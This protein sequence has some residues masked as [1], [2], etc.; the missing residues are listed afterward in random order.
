M[1]YKCILGKCRSKPRL[2]SCS[3]SIYKCFSGG[4]G[5]TA[6]YAVVMA[7][8]IVKGERKGPHPFM[9]QLRD[10]DTHQPLPGIT[11]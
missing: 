2:I 11:V 10:E 9:V 1:I 5:K 3:S 7:E 6:N 4:L 8:L